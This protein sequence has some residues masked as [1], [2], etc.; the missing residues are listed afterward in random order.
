MSVNPILKY[1]IKENVVLPVTSAATISTK[2]T[3]DFKV[4]YISESNSGTNPSWVNL[5]INYS[6]I[7]SLLCEMEEIS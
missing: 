5:F 4:R 1:L 3:G 6:D 2:F 7:I